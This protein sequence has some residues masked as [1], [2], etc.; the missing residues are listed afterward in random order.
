MPAQNLR[1]YAVSS[2]HSAHLRRVIALAIVACGL[3][4]LALVLDQDGSRR[5]GKGLEG[6]GQIPGKVIPFRFHLIE[7]R[8]Q[9]AKTRFLT[10]LLTINE[11]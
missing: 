10:S 3:G 7:S 5:Q 6:S 9:T 8:P 4:R 2:N 11:L 1:P